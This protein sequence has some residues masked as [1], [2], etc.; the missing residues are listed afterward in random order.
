MGI[1]NF[2]LRYEPELSWKSWS[3]IAIFACG[4]IGFAS[5]VSVSERPGMPESDLLAKAYYTL[6]LYVLGGMDLGT[7]TGGPVWGRS[8]L[9][10]AYFGA[11]I[12][13][14]SAIFETILSALRPQVRHLKWM[15]SKIVIIG[16]GE[17]TL[18]FLN[19]IAASGHRRVVVIAD[20]LENARLEELHH[21]R[22]VSVIQASR[23]QVYRIKYY[24]FHKAHRLLL[25]SERDEVNFE[26]ASLLL[27]S[28]PEM[29][30]RI[31][32]HVSNLRFLRV[33]SDS[34]V[35]R[36][37]IAFNNYELAATQLAREQLLRHFNA[38]THRDTV[39]LAGFGRFGQSILEQLEKHAMGAFSQVAIIDLQAQRRAMIADEEAPIQRSY[40]RHTYQG[41]IDDPEVWLHLFDEVAIKEQAPVFV[42]TTGNDEINLRSAIWLRRRFSNALIISRTMAPSAFARGVCEEHDIVSVNT[43]ELVESSI[44]HAWCR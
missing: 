43:V 13:T 39:I 1:A 38:T 31:V 37:C 24:P 2:F 14:A 35:V 29:G 4:L 32:F 25:L 12:W 15:R 10:A 44:P 22:L 8:L 30:S 28:D 21:R 42:I 7:P 27:E 16:G 36:R 9:W 33:L 17:M 23:E 41:D 40:V 19:R 34:K 18:G 6:G 11:P 3:A 26:A 5:G 20:D